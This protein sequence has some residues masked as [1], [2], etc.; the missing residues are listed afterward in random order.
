[1]AARFCLNMIVRDESHVIIRCLDNV[2][3]LLDAVAIV[4]TGSL[5][6]TVELIEGYLSQHKIR[7]GVTREPWR[8]F[9]HNRTSAIRYAEKVVAGIDGGLPNRPVSKEEWDKVGRG[10]NWYL[11]FMDA[12]N[13]L[14]ADKGERFGPDRTKLVADQYLIDMRQSTVTYTYN[15][16]VKLDLRGKR[17]WHWIGVLHEYLGA[18]GDWNP[19]L[20]KVTGGYIISGREGSRNKDP[21]KYLADAVVLERE[22]V[23]QPKN[24]RYWFYLAQS[25]RDAVRYDEAI[26]CYLKRAEMGGWAEEV[27]ISYLEVAKMQLGR[28]ETAHKGYEHLLRA[29]EIRPS[30]LEP[31]YYLVRACRLA[32]LFKIGWL[33][34]SQFI[35]REQTQETL[36]VDWNITNW[37]FLD[38][39]AVCAYHAG[40]KENC[41]KLSQRAI[42]QAPNMPPAELERIKKNLSS[43]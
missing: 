24:E 15:W 39:A 14:C 18:E 13:T 12:D 19:T 36:F 25:Y 27:F 21:V 40:D 43:C 4:D 41:K 26:R 38:E 16:L 37:M 30:R 7:G 23:S 11:L 31:A 28:P 2:K 5:D 17:R 6:N 9:G 3:H 29:I 1:M 10:G 34:A 32:R 20:G 42:K 35:D 22:L 33:I 8:N